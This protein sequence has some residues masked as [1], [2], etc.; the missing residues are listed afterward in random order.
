MEHVLVALNSHHTVPSACIVIA[1]P[2]RGKG[3]IMLCP[4]STPNFNNLPTPVGEGE[5]ANVH[6][7][8]RGLFLSN[9][10]SA[11]LIHFLLGIL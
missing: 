1:F 10:P 2:P 5:E 9:F 7:N 8:R 6:V 4:C 3:E 11:I